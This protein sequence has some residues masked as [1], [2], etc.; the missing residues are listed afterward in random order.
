MEL[1]NLLMS[2]AFSGWYSM[3]ASSV[4]GKSGE[5]DTLLLIESCWVWT[6]NISMVNSQC[7]SC[8]DGVRYNECELHVPALSKGTLISLLLV[9]VPLPDAWEKKSVHFKKKPCVAKLD[10]YKS[11]HAY[12]NIQI[13]FF[14]FHKYFKY[15]T[16]YFV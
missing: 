15:V 11:M 13:Y 10:K 16:I 1:P 5:G 8:T 4:S 14:I 12:V 2:T 3:G 9:V 6:K 7:I